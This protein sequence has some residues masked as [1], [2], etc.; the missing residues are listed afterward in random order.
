M[1]MM[2]D[3]DYE[4]EAIE[5][6][7]TA[8][9]ESTSWQIRSVLPGFYDGALVVVALWRG[10][11]Y[12][13]QVNVYFD[14]GNRPTV[15]AMTEDLAKALGARRPREKW[16]IVLQ[17]FL[18]VNG[19]AAMVAI[20]VTITICALV[21]FNPSKQIPEILAN[22]LTMILGFYFGTKAAKR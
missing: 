6:V 12:R 5:A 4:Y 22:A 9:P 3:H 10:E 7:K 17:Y 20:L 21:L 8:Y 18:S 2:T 1:V 13:G 14:E 15:F 11:E 16:E 19:V